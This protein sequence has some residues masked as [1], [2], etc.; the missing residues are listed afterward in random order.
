MFVRNVTY[1]LLPQIGWITCD[2]ASNNS[3][4]LEDFEECIN[5]HFSHRNMKKWD[6]HS[7]YVRALAHVVNLATQAVIKAYSKWSHYDTQKPEAHVPDVLAT[8]RD[9][10]GL[11]IFLRVPRGLP[12]QA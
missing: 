9:D 12:G 6:C 5:N 11:E 8:D 3:T 7:H 4:M 1:L 2:N 10:I